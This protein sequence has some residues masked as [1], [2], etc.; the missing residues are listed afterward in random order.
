MRAIVQDRYGEVDVLQLCDIPTPSI[1]D[2]EVLIEVRAGG[3]DPGVWHLMTGRPYLVRLI[4][5]GLRKHVRGMDVAGVVGS[6]GNAA[7]GF[8][9]GDEVFGTCH[10]S[11]AEYSTACPDTLAHKPTNLTFEEAAVVPVSAC[12]ALQAVRN[13]GRV[14]AGQRVLIIGAGGGVGTFA[15]QIAKAYGAE[16]TGLCSTTKTQLVRSIGADS[17]IDYTREDVA[18]GRNR[19]DLIVDTAGR[20]PL[21]QLRRALPTHGTIVIVGGEGGGRWLGGFDRGFRGHLMGPLVRQR[22]R[23]VS[24]KVNHDDLVVLKRPHRGGQDPPRHRHHLSPERGPQGHPPLGR[25]QQPRKDRHH[26]L[27]TEEQKCGGLR[28]VG[29]DCE[30]RSPSGSASAGPAHIPCRLDR[31]APQSARP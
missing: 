6:V 25:R 18:D 11:F 13:Q 16:V 7:E 29:G 5:H 14:K 28:R 15:V 17:V 26:H 12:T 8:Q 2:D 21:S 22:I 20:R 30:L 31:D 27:T 3:L 19:Y 4:G 23:Q 10:G 24:A 1:K 9:P